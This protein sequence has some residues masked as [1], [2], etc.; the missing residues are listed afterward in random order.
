M[1]AL[2]T[3]F[4]KTVS[5]DAAVWWSLEILIQVQDLFWT[6]RYLNWC[7]LS[8]L[9]DL[10]CRELAERAFLLSEVWGLT[11]LATWWKPR[12][13]RAGCSSLT[14]SLVPAAQAVHQLLGRPWGL[15]TEDAVWCV[16]W[17]YTMAAP[18]PCPSSSHG[19]AL[20]QGLCLLGH[21]IMWHM[22]DIVHEQNVHRWPFGEWP[23][24]A[25]KVASGP[26]SWECYTYAWALPFLPAPAKSHQEGQGQASTLCV[27]PQPVMLCLVS[28]L[29]QPHGRGLYYP[30]RPQHWQLS[31][32][33]ALCSCSAVGCYCHLRSSGLLH[34]CD[35]ESS[36]E[37]SDPQLPF[38]L[39][40]RTDCLN[41]LCILGSRQEGIAP[42]SDHERLKDALSF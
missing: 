41:M 21:R 28:H 42:N 6:Q 38:M 4:C 18:V 32:P 14:P 36:G 7:S 9:A 5:E 11:E 16:S 27:S 30:L 15:L 29:T 26:G 22:L 12:L 40:S 39:P 35:T 24:W 1:P 23:F 37:A 8:T 19:T 31:K 2:S 20:Q 17:S 13:P 34:T 10:D 33:L 25:G 3:A